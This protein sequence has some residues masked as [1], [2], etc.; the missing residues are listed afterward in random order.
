MAHSRPTT[1]HEQRSREWVSHFART[2][3]S[4]APPKSHRQIRTNKK[5]SQREK[6]TNKYSKQEKAK[7]QS[8]DQTT[9]K[10]S[11]FASRAE[12]P[13]SALFGKPFEAL[14]QRSWQHTPLFSRR[15]VNNRS[16]TT[17]TSVWMH[18]KRRG[19]LVLFIC[20]DRCG[21]EELTPRRSFRR[22]QLQKW[23]WIDRSKDNAFQWH[24]W[25][26]EMVGIAILVGLTSLLV[27]ILWFWPI[28]EIWPDFNLMTYWPFWTLIC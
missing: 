27:L 9:H 6:A 23:L 28:F 13:I 25:G 2:R 1:S 17:L 18:R 3:V 12:V 11:C 24:V 22:R 15:W 20:I 10:W 19:T 8:I 4:T 7:H 26:V 14:M 5:K 21:C 16:R